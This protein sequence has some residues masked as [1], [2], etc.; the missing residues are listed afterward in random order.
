[1]K[2]GMRSWILLLS[3]VAIGCA[4]PADAAPQLRLAWR[5]PSGEERALSAIQTACD[6]TAHVDTLYLTFE[7]DQPRPEL[8]WM[9]ATLYFL[10][11]PGDS[12][13]DFWRFKRGTANG[14][15]LWVHFAPF[16]DVP[17]NP[18]WGLHAQSLKS[19]VSYDVVGGRGRLKLGAYVPERMRE[20]LRPRLQYTLAR[21]L[22]Y[23]RRA[24]LAGCTQPV[25]VEWADAVMHF[26][27]GRDIEA[28]TGDRF[29]AWN[30]DKDAVCGP[31]ARRAPVRTWRPR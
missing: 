21:V 1:M 3:L 10:P 23:H 8:L 7:L 30:G 16:T 18:P 15:N 31:H 25:C 11:Q 12:L 14:G 9:E 4:T 17:T 27:T 6:D 20:W 13:G 5:A 26:S 28:T 19:E 2:S 24:D 22:V 29:A